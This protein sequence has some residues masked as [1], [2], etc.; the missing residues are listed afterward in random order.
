M[1]SLKNK[2]LK[3]INRINYDY[4]NFLDFPLLVKNK[5]KLND[6]LLEK[7]IEVRFKHYYNCEKMFYNTK[8]CINA[9]KYENELICLPVHQKIKIKY[10]EYVFLNLKKYFS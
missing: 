7:N 4:Q 6:F 1:S 5:K 9:E 10:M 8:L 3:F 2:N